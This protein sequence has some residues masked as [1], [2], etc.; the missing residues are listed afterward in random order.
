MAVDTRGAVLQES[1]GCHSEQFW[2]ET[3]SHTRDEDKR[4]IEKIKIDGS[5][6]V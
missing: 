1:S 2:I 5:P 6:F 3:M 4:D